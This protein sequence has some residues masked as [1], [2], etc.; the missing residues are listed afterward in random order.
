[1]NKYIF[2]WAAFIFPLSGMGQKFEMDTLQWTGPAEQ[3]I[4]LVFL[5]EGY[6]Q[7]EL[8]FFMEDAVK[9][10]KHFFKESPFKEYQSY[11][12]LIAIRVP[13]NVSGAARDPANLIDN[14]FG[15]SFNTAGI[16]R[17]LV[18]TKDHL[19]QDILF[20][21]FPLFDQ[22]ILIVNDTKYGGSGGWLATTSID[23]NAPEIALH[24]IGHSF[25]GLAD[26]YWVGNQ[27]ASEKPNMTQTTDPAKIKWR[28]W[29]DFMDVGIYPH[30]GDASWVKPHQSCKMQTLNP[31]FCPVCKQQI[32]RSILTLISPV[33]SMYPESTSLTI[34]N[35]T[36]QFSLELLSPN[37]NTLSVVW[38]IDSLYQHQ[39]STALRL[40]GETLIP[41]T[42]K[43]H[44]YIRDT[45]H[46]IRNDTW[47]T[48]IAYA[49]DWWVEK[50]ALTPLLDF[51]TQENIVLYPNPASDFISI[52]LGPKSLATWNL[53][54][55][56][57]SGK[58]L[59]SEPIFS[60]QTKDIPVSSIPAGIYEVKITGPAGWITK[61]LIKK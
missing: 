48:E 46:Y 39:D 35:D 25:A 18:A 6:Q 8:A 44:A 12:N 52:T 5:S 34:K 10:G 1:M 15:S 2:W 36:L 57:M 24:E 16:D 21:Q 54:L 33:I 58:I 7:E 32:A 20:D 9:V 3:R 13:S 60:N 31:P 19:A 47:D 49:H 22:A 37:P 4:N 28:K 38:S 11:F 27:Y 29:L 26:E 55:I 43:V 14:Y 40:W 45:T 59:F 51:Q 50:G 61:K 42:Y 56:D 41:G 53:E 23:I 17:L 30:S